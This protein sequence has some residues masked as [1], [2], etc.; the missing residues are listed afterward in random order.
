MLGG[1]LGALIGAALGH[2]LDTHAVGPHT[3]LAGLGGGEPERVQS[4]FFTATFSVLGH[5][6]KADGRVSEAEI[7]LARTVMQRLGLTPELRRAAIR[8]FTEGKAPG[9]PL[10]EVLLRF[11]QECGCRRAVL[12]L[13]LE[14]QLR[15][16]HAN[17]SPHPRQR[18]LL[19]HI[20][21]GLGLPRSELEALEAA[22]REQP[23]G[24]V[25]GGA[26]HSLHE[27][28]TL[29]GVAAN[30]S[31]EAVKTA[32]RRLMNQHHPDKLIARG[33][34]EDMMR[35]ATEKTCEIRTAYE[36]IREARGF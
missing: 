1:P 16:A 36:A 11:R 6:A 28:Y 22:V 33:A 19:L 9:F 34:P 31:N 14:I 20:C 32:Y 21:R 4:A 24:R 25:R 23:A 2:K 17:G 3:L 27:A 8:L 5:L 13:F 18:E 26:R 15:G 10:D 29:L 12:R 30:A 7:A 35:R